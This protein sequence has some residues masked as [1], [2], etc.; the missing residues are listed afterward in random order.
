MPDDADRNGPLWDA[1]NRYFPPHSYLP[2]LL[3]HEIYL[4][5][6]FQPT[7]PVLSMAFNPIPTGTEGS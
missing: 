5:V 7:P 3:N 1:D 6:F 4:S 2:L